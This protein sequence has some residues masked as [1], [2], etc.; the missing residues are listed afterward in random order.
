MT[1]LVIKEI[2]DV[3]E[4]GLPILTLV[5]SIMESLLEPFILIQVLV[6]NV[7]QMVE[8]TKYHLSDLHMDVVT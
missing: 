6:V 3:M 1:V 7:R 2:G 5:S 4:A 8:T